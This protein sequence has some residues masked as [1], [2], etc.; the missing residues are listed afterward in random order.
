MNWAL[1]LLTLAAKWLKDHPEVLALI[2]EAINKLALLERKD[3]CTE[4]E[5]CL[6]DQKEALLEALDHNAHLCDCCEK[7]K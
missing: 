3:C 7:S 1:G 2:Q 4:M 6:A 5:K